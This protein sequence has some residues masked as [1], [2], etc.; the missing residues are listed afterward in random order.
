[1]PAS[2]LPTAT[3]V[4]HHIQP[5]LPSEG[6]FRGETWVAL[7]ERLLARTVDFLPSLL[8][9]ILVLAFF[10][11]A[12][13]L[14]ARLLDRAL[15]RPHVDAALGQILPPLLRY[16][17]LALGLIMALSQAGFQVGSLLAGVG[18]AGLAMGLAA[19][20]TLGNLIAGFS[21]LWDR[22]FRIGDRVTIAATYGQVTQI[23]LRST[24]LRTLD[25]L[26][27]ILPN[28]EVVNKV[29][30]N[31]TL[32]PNLRLGVPFSVAYRE[33]VARVRATLLAAVAG[34][35]RLRED[36]PAEV[37]VTALGDSA[38][39]LELRVWLVDPM[40]ERPTLF[41]LLEL[42]K[43]ALE[44]AGIEIPFPQRDLHLDA[45]SRRLEV[46]VASVASSGPPD[47]G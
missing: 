24:R 36:P 43:S 4:P 2:V 7:G 22:P 29:I 12:S 42:I 27:V 26:D 46:T 35:P 9:A 16:T 15:R 3:P 13:R 41:A 25:Q 17:V 23:G 31:H 30:V 44:S 40:T 8:A 10:L 33:D 1:M 32:T 28:R 39:A 45:A 19:Q 47:A 18:V 5:L 37:V 38:V 21:L 20:D 34:N 14:A 6:L 11:L